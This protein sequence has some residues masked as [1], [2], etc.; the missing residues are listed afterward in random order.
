[1]NMYVYMYVFKN[2]NN[3][4][5]FIMYVSQRN[6]VPPEREEKNK[7]RNAMKT[8]KTLLVPYLKN[9]LTK[10]RKLTLIVGLGTY[11]CI[12]VCM[13]VCIYAMPAIP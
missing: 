4:V 13:Y 7:R 3:F 2:I 8:L 9:Y 5:V 10:F 6:I 1:M 12:D 11:V